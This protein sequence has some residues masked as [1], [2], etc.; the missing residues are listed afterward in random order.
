MEQIGVEDICTARIYKVPDP[1]AP[2]EEEKKGEDAAE[3]GE[4]EKNER[5][6]LIGEMASL[7][8]LGLQNGGR[9]EVEVYF[10]IEVSVQSA[11]AGYNVVVEVGPEETMDTI[12]SRVA[13][14]KM[15]R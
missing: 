5:E 14:F 12:E 13:W 9:L 2:P 11:G 10:S 6:M 7:E 1:N 3:G 8:T 4:G 15:F